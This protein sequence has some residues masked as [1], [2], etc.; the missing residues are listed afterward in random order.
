MNRSINLTGRNQNQRIMGLGSCCI[1]C[2]L[3]FFNVLFGILGL[4]VLA[5]GVFLKVGA[6]SYI[7]NYAAPILT[8]LISLPSFFQN[9]ESTTNATNSSPSALLN[10]DVILEP[11]AIVL[12]VLGCVVACLAFLGAFGACCNSKCL[13]GTY[14]VFLCIIII[15]EIVLAV[16]FFTQ[17]V[18][19][20][21]KTTLQ[22]TFIDNYVGI[23]D[24]GIYSLAS[25][26]LMLMFKCCGLNDYLDFD[27]DQDMQRTM[28]V[29]DGKHSESVNLT[30]PVSCCKF[31]GDFPEIQFPN[32]TTCASAP[33]DEISNWKTGCW[34]QVTSSIGSYRLPAIGIV[35]GVIVFEAFFTLLAIVLLCAMNKSKVGVE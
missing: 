24:L 19:S 29:S 11:V 1:K 32:I 35:C 5:A 10:F 26:V 14:V 20:Q 21:I 18:D 3:I 9:T 23:E 33:T 28:T 27:T 4:I 25:N 8:S 30:T 15:I 13:L 31:T 22:K 12:I 34:G 7:T 6:A 16:L 17:T 2:F